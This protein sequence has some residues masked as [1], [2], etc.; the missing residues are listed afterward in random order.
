MNMEH[1]GETG[2]RQARRQ[3]A[4]QADDIWYAPQAPPQVSG[5]KGC[6]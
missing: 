2:T 6:L 4:K 1:G 5:A 3:L